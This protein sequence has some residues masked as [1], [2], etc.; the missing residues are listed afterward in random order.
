MFEDTLD[1]LCD[2]FQLLQLNHILNLIDHDL[3]I[4]VNDLIYMPFHHIKLKDFNF[5][6]ELHFKSGLDAN[7]Y[8]LSMKNNFLFNRFM[9]ILQDNNA[10]IPRDHANIMMSYYIKG[11]K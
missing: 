5:T 3:H 9:S 11:F 4:L 10:K 8:D 2:D 6:N 1:D 7:T